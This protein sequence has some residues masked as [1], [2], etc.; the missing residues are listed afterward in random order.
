MID[1]A[2]LFPSLVLDSLSALPVVL[3]RCR[4]IAVIA[5]PAFLQLRPAWDLYVFALVRSGQIPL[6]VSAH[7]GNVTLV[8]RFMRF[9]AARCAFSPGGPWWRPGTRHCGLRWGQG[10]SGPGPTTRAGG[11]APGGLRL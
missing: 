9:D 2:G 4:R 7:I 8:G 6:V 10:K 5:G 11:G 3:A 1:D